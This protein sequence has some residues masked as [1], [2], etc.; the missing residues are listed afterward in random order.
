MSDANER[1]SSNN[2]VPQAAPDGQAIQMPPVNQTSV[3]QNNSQDG[4][5]L[6]AEPVASQGNADYQS[7]PP[8]HA[9]T[10]Y[11]HAHH[12]H[13]GTHMPHHAQHA[14]HAGQV[15]HQYSTSH[16][17]AGSAEA[18]N[19]QGGR[20]F[21]MGFAG[22]AV[23][24]VIG[25]GG[26]GL[27]QAFSGAAVSLDDVEESG[28][29]I[30]VIAEGESVDLAEIVAD[31]ALPSVVYVEVLASQSNMF[32]FG[33]TESSGSLVPVSTGSGVVITEDGYI[34]TNAHVIEGAEAVE[35]TIEG[36]VYSADIVGSDN[37]SDV[38][39]LKVQNGSGFTPVELG[40]SDEL[41]IGEWVMTI[42]SPF[43]LEQSV[44]TGIVSATNRSQIVDNTTGES[45][46]YPNMIQTDAAIN[47]GNS[48]GALVNQEG[49]LIGINTLIASSSGNYSGVGFAIPVNYAMD[50]AQQLIDGASPTHA[51]LGVSLLTVDDQTAQRYG[52]SVNSGAYVVSIDEGTGAANSDLMVGDIIMKFN[53]VDVESASDLILD[54]R[55]VNPGDTVTLEV[56]R[57][58]EMVSVEVTLGSDAGSQESEVSQQSSAG[59][60]FDQLFGGES[61]G[62]VA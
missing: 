17:S 1:P 29:S 46:I 39:V 21:L 9:T 49:Q 57:N 54:V 61:S 30:E 55:S 53:G 8:G 26:F 25:L 60:A 4:V 44:A 38:A 10:G 27:W 51:Q 11:G 58:G 34:I 15:P 3:L 62:N 37:S 36:E 32:G 24:C 59:S 23:A 50:I 14:A 41:I 13:T 47:P 45:T 19:S 33:G 52:L 28:A 18:K 40:D 48:G 20:T 56:D 5:T 42:G 31:K 2:P 35:V 6:V 22:A 7:S 12:N 43:G 16:V